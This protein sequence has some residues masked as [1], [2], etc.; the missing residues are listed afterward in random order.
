MIRLHAKVEVYH[1]RLSPLLVAPI[2]VTPLEFCQDLWQENIRD[3][4]LSCGVVWVMI[5]LAVLIELR[6]VAD[7]RADTQTQHHSTYRASM[8]SRSKIGNV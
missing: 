5:Y 1:P 3:P 6:L 2:W 8:A 4:E 7:R